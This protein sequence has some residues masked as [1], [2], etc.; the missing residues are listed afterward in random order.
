MLVHPRGYV[1][2]FLEKAHFTDFRMPVGTGMAYRCAPGVLLVL[3][4]F[5]PRARTKL[6]GVSR[7]CL[8]G[9]EKPMVERRLRPI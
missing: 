9:I 5:S 4:T 3:S 8:L 6:N 2:R 1:Q 7:H